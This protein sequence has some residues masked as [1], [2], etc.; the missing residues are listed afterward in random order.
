MK[1]YGLMPQRP[2]RI[3]GKQFVAGATLIWVKFRA[4]PAF[5]C[6]GVLKG[7]RAWGEAGVGAKARLADDC[8]RSSQI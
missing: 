1:S 6:R 7:A 2:S 3:A 4:G 5:A 8:N